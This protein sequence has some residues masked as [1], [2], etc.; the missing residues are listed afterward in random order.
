MC[1]PVFG[2]GAYQAVGR[3]GELGVPQV[4]GRRRFLLLYNNLA[5]EREAESPPRPCDL[6]VRNSG[7]IKS[8]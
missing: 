8:C 7:E 3:D 5:M 6:Y 1:S 2:G 4:T